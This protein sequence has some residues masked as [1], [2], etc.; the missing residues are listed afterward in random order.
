MHKLIMFF[1]GLILLMLTFAAL[2][3]S[4]ALFDAGSKRQI[5]SFVFQPNDLSVG[6]IGRPIP[7]DELSEK[8][9]LERLI[10]KFVFEYFYATPDVE[11]IAQ[12]TR[13][14][15]I[16]SAISAPD[17]FQE[18]KNTEAK[19]IEKLAGEKMLRMVRV[20]DEI[21]LKGDY[22]EVYYELITWDEPNNMNLGPKVENAIIYIKISFGQGVRDRIN[23]RKFDVQKYLNGGGDPAAIFKFTVDGVRR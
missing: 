6:R 21:L 5:K 15:S 1:A 19:E 4:G 7:V 11:N 13:G 8:F 14:N 17:V 3:F 2:Y 18:W 23:G 20:A 12:R 22:L 10:K 16:L 9:I